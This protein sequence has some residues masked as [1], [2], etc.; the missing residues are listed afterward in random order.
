MPLNKIM[1]TL[2]SLRI[3]LCLLIPLF[4]QA[5]AS[6]PTKQI[7]YYDFGALP[8]AEEQAPVCSLPLVQ[9]ADIRAPSAL[10][11]NLML[12][13]LLYLNDQ[14]I[15][16][17]ANHRWN[18]T[19]AQLLTQRL[20]SQLARRGVRLLDG[21]INNLNAVQLRLEIEDFNHYFTD[22]TRSYA[23]IQIR[24][25]LIRDRK[26]LAQTLLQQQVDAD[27]ADAPAGAKA[28]RMATDELILNLTNWLCEQVK[29]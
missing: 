26:L 15:Y 14:Q 28:M 20:K 22:A 12:Y 17:Y 18:M 1:R 11:S 3:L 6:T 16:S 4:L 2:F 24:A 19:P 7:K 5:C 29:Q 25:S 9:L 8:K 13:R 21:G 23:Q 27:T 10:S